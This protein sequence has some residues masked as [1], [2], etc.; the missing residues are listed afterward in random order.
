[1]QNFEDSMKADPMHLDASD[2]EQ[3]SDDAAKP[4][5]KKP[6]QYDED[7]DHPMDAAVVFELLCRIDNITPT[8]RSWTTQG[9]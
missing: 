9:L 7:N 6:H 1:M 2:A 4:A 8:S 3:S 5:N